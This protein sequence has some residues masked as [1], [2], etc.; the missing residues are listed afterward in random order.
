MLYFVPHS[1]VV[2]AVDTILPKQGLEISLKMQGGVSLLK[3][4][5]PRNKV[6]G[7]SYILWEKKS[8]AE[9]SSMF[10]ALCFHCHEEGPTLFH[11]LTVLSKPKQEDV[12]NKKVTR[13]Q[14]E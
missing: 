13:M 7:K 1:Q 4:W 10:A 11:F 12:R 6:S 5:P 8:P 3:R 9:V 2:S 14:A